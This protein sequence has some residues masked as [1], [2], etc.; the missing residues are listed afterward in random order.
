MNTSVNSKAMSNAA[1]GRNSRS[2]GYEMLELFVLVFLLCLS[3]NSSAGAASIFSQTT[4]DAPWGA[5]GS[6]D[7]AN[8]QKIADDFVLVGT[9][10]KTVRSLRFIGGYVST[11]PPP[12]TPPLENLPEDSFRILFYRDAAGIPGAVAPGGSFSVGSMIS[13]EPTGGPLLGGAATPLQFIVDLG[14]GVP[15]NPN[16]VYWLSITNNPGSEHGW[17]WATALGAS[18][19]LASTDEDLGTG[20]WAVGTNGS[21]WFELNDANVPEPTAW[22]LVLAGALATPMRKHA[23]RRRQATIA[24][25]ETMQYV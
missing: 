20:P 11:T 3:G 16:E 4:P 13:R 21:M 7:K 15:L 22:R 12:L 23:I 19:Q 14:S 9:T 18:G 1:G 6:S 2:C 24:S 5:Y 25:T 17:V 8:S 10:P